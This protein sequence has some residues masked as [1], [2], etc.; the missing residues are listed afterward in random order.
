MD[1]WR[2]FSQSGAF[3]CFCSAKSD[4]LAKHWSTRSRGADIVARTVISAQLV[5]KCLCF[6][7]LYPNAMRSCVVI[8]KQ[9]T[10]LDLTVF[11]FGL[12][13]TCCIHN[14]TQKISF[15]S[16]L[17]MLESKSLHNR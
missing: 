15:S 2:S 7:L 13:P 16:T 9:S 11:F 3:E 6:F 12:F 17:C 5:E 10:H 4:T 1:P 14:E 8:C